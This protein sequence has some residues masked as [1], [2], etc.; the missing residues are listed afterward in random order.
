MRAV[1][2]GEL[3]RMR[4]DAESRLSD[5]CTIQT[6][7][8]VADGSGGVT[9][10]WANTY[11][12]TPCYLSKTS[13]GAG[14]PA[15]GGK[16]TIHTAWTLAVAYDQAIAAGNRVVMGGDTYEVVSVGDDDTERALRVAN[17]AR[18]DN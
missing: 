14:A 5:T 1:T 18:I 12:S 15:Q 6:R 13:I 17:I 8:T 2:S 4:D 10:T 9:E 3:S 16:F 7:S 11:T